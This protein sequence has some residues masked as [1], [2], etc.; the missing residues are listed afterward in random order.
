MPYEQKDNTFVLFKNDKK[1][2]D[3]H[4]GYT[5]SGMIN[6]KE[7]YVSAWVNVAK[8]GKSYLRGTTKDKDEVN[9]DQR[10]DANVQSNPTPE[11]DLPF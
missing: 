4:P 7:V 10:N 6:G 9:L 8:N 5:G 1:K 3:N 11:N 2:S